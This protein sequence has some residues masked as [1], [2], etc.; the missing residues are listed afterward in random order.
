MEIIDTHCDVL[1]KLAAANGKLSFRN[2]PELDVNL[3]RLQAGRVKVQAFAIFVDPELDSNREQWAQALKQVRYFKEEVLAQP[4]IVQV[5][6]WEEVANVPEGKIGAMLTLEG[7]SPIGNSLERLEMLLDDGVMITSL[8][9]NEGNLCADGIRQKRGAGVSDFGF[10]VIEK[11]NERGVWLDVSHIS[12]AGFWDVLQ[13]ATHVMASH[14]NARAVCGNKRN[15]TD[16][17]IQALISH[18]GLLQLVF[19]PDF[20]KGD[21]TTHA[22]DL[23]VTIDDLMKHVAHII[24]LGGA[25][26]LGLGSDFDGI[27]T[28]VLHLENA[29][30]TKNLLSEIA[31]AYG[32]E[33]AKDVAGKNFV[34]HVTKK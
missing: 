3:E 9:W 12:D 7:C 28:H 8:V 33:V 20:V 22:A 25:K 29:S 5:R 17:Q 11:C 24:K 4:E 14:S 27:E 30:Q 13:S 2:S 26:N 16:E 21:E 1:W 19:C 34:A 10:K 23:T 6:T 32:E 18:D 31:K 15:L